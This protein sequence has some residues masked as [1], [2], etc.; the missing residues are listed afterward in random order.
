MKV[1][2]HLLL[3]GNK[4]KNIHHLSPIYNYLYPNTL[5]FGTRSHLKKHFILH[6]LDEQL[7]ELN[8]NIKL[9]FPF[10]PKRIIK[11]NDRKVRR[12]CYQSF[13]LF[14]KS[15]KRIRYPRFRMIMDEYP[16]PKLDNHI[17]A[18]SH[19][20]SQYSMAWGFDSESRFFKGNT[21]NDE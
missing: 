6:V 18:I 11:V 21:Q 16:R 8:I 20:Y 2:L 4:M 12:A 15:F 13:R 3:V 1:D 14:K 10:N 17:D 5:I 19:F 9:D 7:P